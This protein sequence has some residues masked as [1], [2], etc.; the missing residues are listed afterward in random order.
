M[1][2]FE[3]DV[4][5]M[6]E[7]YLLETGQLMEKLDE[8]LLRSEASGALA[9][10]DINSIFRIMHTTKSSSAIMGLD[11]LQATAHRLEDLFSE[12]RDDPQQMKKAEKE[13]FELLFDASDFIKAEL[14]RMNREDYMPESADVFERRI[15]GC[16]DQIKTPEQAGSGQTEE[17]LPA[18]LKKPGVIVKVTFEQG[19]KMENVRAFML[20]KQLSAACPGAECFPDSPEKHPESA[21]F[22]RESGMLFCIAEEALEKALPILQRGLFV[23][24]CE[25]LAKNPLPVPEAR[26]Q[27]STP[28][29]GAGDKK[30]AD[31]VAVEKVESEFLNVRT[32][33]LDHVQN[34]LGELMLSVASLTSR[35]GGNALW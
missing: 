34:L 22:I 27:A 25:L 6:L 33:R 26:Q 24:Q 8:I 1:S 21:D 29:P 4:Q 16:L 13:I 18:F 28:L 14:G 32:A 35:L 30:E 12:L 31:Y 9:A 17:S 11:S 10:E 15:K 23:S 3:A 7:V 20:M 5:A 2:F 19:C